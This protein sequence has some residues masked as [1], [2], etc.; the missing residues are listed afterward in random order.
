MKL[1][2]SHVARPAW[3]RSQKSAW[4]GEHMAETTG[5]SD[6]GDLLPACEFSSRTLWINTRAR[7][8]FYLVTGDMVS[9]CLP[10]RPPSCKTVAHRESPRPCVAWEDVPS[11]GP[12]PRKEAK[13]LG[14]VLL[15]TVTLHGLSLSLTQHHRL[16]ASVF[17]PHLPNGE[18]SPSILKAKRIV[19]RKRTLGS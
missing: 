12:L 2:P 17:P 11:S 19:P 4:G 5:L 6:P 10:F 7:S 9:I 18:E 15:G 1:K 16:W 3:G 14:A 13:S 8:S